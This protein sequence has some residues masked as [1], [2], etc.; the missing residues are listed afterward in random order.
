MNEKREHPLAPP[1]TVLAFDT[2]TA[3]LSVALVRD[4]AVIGSLHSLAE[5][6]HSVLIV[7]EIKRLMNECGVTSEGINAIAVG[8]GPGSYT[9]V[10]IGVSVGKTLAW[11][12]SKTLLGISSL[13]AL[14][15]GAWESA[16]ASPGEPAAGTV[17]VVPVM[18]ARR[19]Q[20]FTSRMEAD[21]AGG[22]KRMN[23]DAITLS[24]EWADA[25]RQEADQVEGLSAIW[26]VGE[27][28]LHEQTLGKLREDGITVRV[29]PFVMD[30]A[31]VGR[32]AAERYRRGEADDIHAFVP[33]YTQMTE[34]EAKLQ[35]ASRRT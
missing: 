16:E 20:V 31:I 24:A 25:L 19:G 10:R 15:L 12:W 30:A 35:S 9:G 34:A 13:E 33:N 3:S 8:Q 27:T 23:A 5:R 11:T 7:P 14:A 21:R 32:L 29:I 2:S 4:G 22:W 28:A 18:D 6:N 1:I 26:F 17:W